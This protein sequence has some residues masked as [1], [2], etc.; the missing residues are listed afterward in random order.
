VLK[1]RKPVKVKGVE[2]WQQDEHL[3]NSFIEIVR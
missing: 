1:E 2:N 3:Q